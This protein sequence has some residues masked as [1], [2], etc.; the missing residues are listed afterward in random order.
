[1]NEPAITP[2]DIADNNGGILGPAYFAARRVMDKT[3]EGAVHFDWSPILKRARDDFYEKL[4]ETVQDHLISDTESNVQGH[5]RQMVDETVRAILSGEEWALRAYPLSQYYDGA[6][7]RRQILRTAGRELLA[8]HDS[9]DQWGN[10]R[11]RDNNAVYDIERDACAREVYRE[12]N[13]RLTGP[14]P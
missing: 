1:M 3:M 11:A 8:L 12:W 14:R 6:V 7:L 2:D 13:R 9:E 5:I 4:L 10:K